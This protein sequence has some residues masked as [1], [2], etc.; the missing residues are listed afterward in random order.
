MSGLI[1]P[2]RGRLPTIAPGAWVAP[3]ATVIGDVTVGEGSSLWFGV[4]VRGDLCGIRIGARTNLQDG[5]VVH[6]SSRGLG[7][8]IGDDVT[9]G[10]M[11]MIH[12]CRLEDGSFVGMKACVL[13]GAV[14]ETGAMVAAG[15]VVSPGKRVRAGE[16]WTGVPARPMRTLTEDEQQNLIETARHYVDLA[17]DYAA[18]ER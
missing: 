5:T 14:V 8:E 2:Y 12:A 17:A 11:A 10:H 18:E 6:V 9:V 4:I 16:L 1:L 3:T 13:D 7:A 15:A